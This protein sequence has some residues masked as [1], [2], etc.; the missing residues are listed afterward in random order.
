MLIRLSLRRY[1]YTKTCRWMIHAFK[2]G[3]MRDE[4]LDGFLT[5][6][7]PSSFLLLF[8]SYDQLPG[9]DFFSY[10][11]TSKLQILCKK[12]EKEHLSCESFYLLVYSFF[13]LA[14]IQISIQRLQQICIMRMEIWLAQ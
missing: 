3:N 5:P 8:H 6:S 12:I 13:Q 4:G 7:E 14:K 10:K 2:I 9:W 11:Y 1:E